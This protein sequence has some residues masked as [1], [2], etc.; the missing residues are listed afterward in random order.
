MLKQYV[1]FFFPGSFVSETSAQE[2]ANRTDAVE[3]PRGAYGYRFFA[4]QEVEQDGEVLKGER[5]DIGPMT[6]YGEVLTLEDVQALPGDYRILAS[7][8]KC[9][10]WSRVVRT[11][12]G[13]FQPLDVCDVV[14]TPNAEITGRASGP[15]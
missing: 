4:Q 2:V 8:M 3:L 13:N 10:G 5:K 9:N 12:R 7:N 15:G 1:E 6:Y 11:V 14:V